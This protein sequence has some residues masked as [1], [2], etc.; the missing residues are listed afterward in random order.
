MNIAQIQQNAKEL[1]DRM[2]WCE[3][4]PETRI[5][6]LKDE[7]KEVL[8]EVETLTTATDP[9]ELEAAKERY[10]MEVYDFLWNAADLANRYGINLQ[11]MFEKKMDINNNRVF[12]STKSF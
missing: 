12:G 6:Y 8:Q 4:N 1:S 11:E 5:N 10:G 9:V 7:F 2:G 3:Y